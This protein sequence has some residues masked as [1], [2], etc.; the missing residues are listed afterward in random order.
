MDKVSQHEQAYQRATQ[1][2]H[3]R[4][5]SI[6]DVEVA[7][8]HLDLARARHRNKAFPT[9]TSVA[10]CEVLYALWKKLGGID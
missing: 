4:Y 10:D 1:D 8:Q 2:A 5:D 3:G 9:H 7:R 6:T